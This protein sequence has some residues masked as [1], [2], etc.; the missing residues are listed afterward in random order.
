[1]ITRKIVHIIENHTISIYCLHTYRFH[2]S[3]TFIIYSP[4][5]ILWSRYIY[6]TLVGN[7]LA[8]SFKMIHIEIDSV[9]R[10]QDADRQHYLV[11]RIQVDKLMS[12]TSKR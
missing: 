2:S 1:M 7:G 4:I 10:N 6:R 3:P 5:H 11:N 9:L 8:I 12:Q